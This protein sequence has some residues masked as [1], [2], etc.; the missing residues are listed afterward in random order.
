M[1]KVTPLTKLASRGAACH[2]EHLRNKMV[3]NPL[4]RHKLNT[5]LFELHRD[6]INSMFSAQ[7][8]ETVRDQEINKQVNGGTTIEA[9]KYPMLNHTRTQ[10][11]FTFIFSIFF[12]QRSNPTGPYSQMLYV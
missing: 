10:K 1:Q 5:T 11:K 2:E 9:S 8:N 12:N 4:L 3:D 7:H 6:L